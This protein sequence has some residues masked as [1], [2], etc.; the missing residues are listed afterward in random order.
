MLTSM[1][2]KLILG[3]IQIW[4]LKLP[5]SNWIFK[6]SFAPNWL[7]KLRRQKKQAGSWNFKK[8]QI[9]SL[10]LYLHW[11]GHW[12]F[13]TIWALRQ[14]PIERQ[15]YIIVRKVEQVIFQKFNDRFDA[16]D[17]SATFFPNSRINLVQIVSSKTKLVFFK[18][19]RPTPQLSLISNF[20]FK[21]VG[22][23]Q[24]D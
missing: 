1:N 9:W 16:N 24:K 15:T 2:G 3:E 8:G 21:N 18:K 22:Q 19:L 20:Q 5:S 23:K 6:V 4:S 11:V 14:W 10:N 7:L 13:K 12:S 17:I